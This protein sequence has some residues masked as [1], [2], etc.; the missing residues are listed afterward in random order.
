M[1]RQPM[2]TGPQLQSFLPRQSQKLDLAC[3]FIFYNLNV[4][5]FF[6]YVLNVWL[7]TPFCFVGGI[8]FQ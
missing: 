5:K 2:F 4:N 6:G 8:Y 1:V 7:A 3:V